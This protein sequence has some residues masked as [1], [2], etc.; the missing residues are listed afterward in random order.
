M[1]VFPQYSDQSHLT[2]F[3]HASKWQNDCPDLLT[4]FSPKTV[5]VIK[6]NQTWREIHELI[7]WKNGQQLYKDGKYNTEQAFL[8]KC[9]CTIVYNK[10]SRWN[11][12]KDHEIIYIQIW[13]LEKEAIVVPLETH[14]YSWTAEKIVQLMVACGSCSPTLLEL[15]KMASDAPL[16]TNFWQ[17]NTVTQ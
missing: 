2:I 3:K 8:T 1:M 7:H 12:Y 16:S 15:T 4:W 17:N 13:I 10:V 6:W 5:W 9:G 14:K 11:A